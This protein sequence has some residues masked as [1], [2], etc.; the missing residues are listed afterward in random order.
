MNIRIDYKRSHQGLWNWLAENPDKQKAN[1]PG[2]KTL[3]KLRVRI[4]F[5]HCFACGIRIPPEGCYDCLV[6]FG[7]K[8]YPFCCEDDYN[9]YYM[10]YN[11]G[12]NSDRVKYARLIA[13]G[14]K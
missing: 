3:G 7:C 4:P 1:W 5:S 2:F 9:S 12:G 13:N 14:W 8:K 10:K 6:Y 11:Y